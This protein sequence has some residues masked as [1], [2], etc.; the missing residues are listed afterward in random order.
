MKVTSKYTIEDCIFI[1]NQINQQSKVKSN[2][3]VQ[4]YYYFIFANCFAFSAF[5]F[6]LGYY[7]AG[8]ILFL[9][10]LFFLIFLSDKVRNEGYKAFYASFFSDNEFKENEVEF[11][12]DGVS[13]K[14]IDGDT[15]FRW[16]N[17]RKIV[18]TSDKIYLFTQ[19]NGITI[20]KNSF[21]FETQIQEFL[22][23]AK[24]RIPQKFLK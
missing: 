9:I 15:F 4:L 21:E 8:F 23:F 6:F 10:N 3:W 14:S 11:L 18:E 17:F 1:A 16:Q 19:A 24:A 5:L 22:I 2:V 20:T 7:L 12:E 13:C